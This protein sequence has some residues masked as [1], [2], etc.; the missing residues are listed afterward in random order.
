MKPPDDDDADD[1][2]NVLQSHYHYRCYDLGG[3]SGRSHDAE[4]PQHY[5]SRYC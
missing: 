4:A 1:D 3:D 2:E 5:S